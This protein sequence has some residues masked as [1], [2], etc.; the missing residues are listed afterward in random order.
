MTKDVSRLKLQSGLSHEALPRNLREGL[1]NTQFVLI[2]IQSIDNVPEVFEAYHVTGF[3][4][5]KNVSE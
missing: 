4:G 3:A 1:V 5:W 2:G